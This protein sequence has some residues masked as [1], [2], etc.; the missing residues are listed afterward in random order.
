MRRD[1]RKTIDVLVGVVLVTL[2][3]L[4]FARPAAAYPPGT[5]LTITA[6][7]THVTSS[8]T[9]I[10]TAN[11]AKPYTSVK[12]TYGKSSKSVTADASGVA[13][14]ALKTSGTGAWLAKAVNLSETATTTVWA[15]KISLNK[16]SS[17][18]GTSNSVKV[19][20]TQVGSVI[21][22]IVGGSTY[23]ST[24]AGSGTVNVAI[25]TPA[26]GKYNVLVYVGAQLMATLK[27][28]AK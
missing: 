10:F 22:V 19:Q 24:G 9:V 15:P 28:D 18:P 11:H 8:E 1:M 5:A 12:F 14:V 20:Y 16:S 6:S 17:K 21:T 3:V 23:T 13:V 2:V 26:K 4:G 7:K 27:L 25:T